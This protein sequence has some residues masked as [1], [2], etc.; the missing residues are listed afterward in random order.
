MKDAFSQLVGEVISATDS[1][2]MGSIE[3]LLHL[4]RR[5]GGERSEFH[6]SA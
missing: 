2:Y 1:I 6:F 5:D 3:K 4:S